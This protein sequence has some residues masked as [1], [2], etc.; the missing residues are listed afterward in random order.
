MFWDCCNLIPIYIRSRYPVIL[1]DY[2]IISSAWFGWDGDWIGTTMDKLEF[3]Y[4]SSRSEKARIAVRLGR[5]WPVLLSIMTI[6]ILV[7]GI[8]LLIIELAVGWAVIGLAVVPA[9]IAEWCNGE[10]KNLIAIDKPRSLDDVISVDVLGRLSRRPTPR[11]LAEV[12]SGVAGG[13]FFAARFGISP[14]FLR[15]LSSDSDADML[16]VWQEAWN[17]QQQIGSKN[18]SAAILIVALIKTSPNYQYLLSHLQLNDDGLIDGIKWYDYLVGLMNDR[19]APRRTGGIARDWS[20]GRTP[21]LNHFGVNIS[22]QVGSGNNLDLELASHNDSLE[23]LV[24]TFGE[25]GR[26]N[27]VLVGPAGSG[28]TQVL[29]AFASKLVDVSVDISSNLRFRKLFVLDAS[30]LIAAASGRGELEQLVSKI[31]VEAYYSNNVIICLDNAHLFF[32]DGIGSVDISNIILPAIELGGLRMIFTMNEQQYLKISGR[33]PEIIGLLSQINIAPSSKSETIAIMQDSLINIEFQHHVTY[34]YQALN[35]AYNLGERYVNEVAM[36]SGALKLLEPAAHY[37]ENGLVTARSVQQAIEKTLGIKI[38]ITTGDD[39]RDKLLNMEQLIHERLVNQSRAV[40]V[41]SDALR[42]AKT[43]V[44]NNNRPISAFLFLGSA[45]VGK[46][47][48]AKALAAIYFG[49]EDRMIR[50]DMNEYTNSNDVVRLI[51]DGP[52]SLATRVRK[53]PFSVVLLNEIDKANPSMLSKILHILDDGILHDIKNREISFRDT[54]VIATSNASADKIQEYIDR[55]YDIEKY[56][57]KLVEELASGGQF[58]LEFLNRFDEIVMFRPLNKDELIQVIDLLIDDV[59]K[60]LALK[61]IIVA[62]TNTAKKYIVDV[63][64]NP[65]L[66]AHSVYRVVQRAVEDAVASQMSSGKIEPD[67]TIRITLNQVRK[68]IDVTVDAERIVNSRK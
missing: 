27:A 17:L 67:S 5:K 60:T 34:M 10:L 68:I 22:Q 47:E 38:G 23:L 39:E 33:D 14:N 46:T 2:P 12:V 50:L 66:G 7:L 16:M 3:N 13:Q 61:K 8:Y 26:Q 19:K 6:I 28:K 58:N 48:L 55:G 36:P 42:R 29:R 59:N 30:V 54:I 44:R 37:N 32:E 18:I 62:I 9:M 56:E 15:Y 51:T 4:K 11:E 31:L 20:F 49:D 63:G 25:K 57:D 40:K 24:S 64:Y 21:L 41:V 43:S 45:G 65:H 1:A 53:Q 35:E 52:N